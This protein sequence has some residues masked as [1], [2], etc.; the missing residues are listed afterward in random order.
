[1][2]DKEKAEPRKSARNPSR[3]PENSVF[4][5]K[6]VPALLVILGILM[7]AMVL[8]AAAVIMGLIK[9]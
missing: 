3:M 7:V 5:N 6:V 1:M 4:Y 9:F 8:F 2:V